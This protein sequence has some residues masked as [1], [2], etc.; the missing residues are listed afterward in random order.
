MDEA[1]DVADQMELGIGADVPRGVRSPVAALVGR[2]GRVATLGKCWKLMPPGVLGLGE[3]VAE[4][5]QRTLAG[6]GNVHVDAI[7]S[8]GAVVDVGQKRLPPL[9]CP[10][11]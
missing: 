4:D 3:A 8:H 7:G 5:H 11:L 1:D 2:H 6:F 9:A 10:A